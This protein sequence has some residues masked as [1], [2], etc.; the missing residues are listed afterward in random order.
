[1]THTREWKSHMEFSQGFISKLI[2][3]QG[4]DLLVGGLSLA[5]I[6]ERYVGGSEFNLAITCK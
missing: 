2:S 3:Y 6:S 4:I 5:I 1:M